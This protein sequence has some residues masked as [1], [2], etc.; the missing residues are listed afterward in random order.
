MNISV[1]MTNATN[2]QYHGVSVGSFVSMDVEEYLRGVVPVEMNPDQFPLEALRVQAI[3]ARTFALYMNAYN[4][5][6]LT[7]TSSKA[8]AYSAGYHRDLRDTAIYST[9]GSVVGYSGKYALA[10]YCASNGGQS[11]ERSDIPYLIAKDDPWT[12]ASGRAKSGHGYGMSQ[13]GAKYAVE[14]GVPIYQILR[15]YYDGATICEGYDV[16]G[17][18]TGSL[19]DHYD[20]AEYY[21]DEDYN[22]AHLDFGTQTLK[23][24]P[25]GMMNGTDV[26]NVQTRLAYIGFDPGEINGVYNK[27]TEAAVKQL[28]KYWGP[29]LGGLTYDGI[30]GNNTKKALRHPLMD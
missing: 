26:Q 29:Y 23:Y 20:R 28:Q 4:P 24:L 19:R 2:A 12:A 10:Q 21:S 11:S 15:F 17:T 8:Q 6:N 14:Q 1:K 16:S 25:S 3:A 22:T 5:Q 7:D 30:V 18:L 13:Y 27:Q 9:E